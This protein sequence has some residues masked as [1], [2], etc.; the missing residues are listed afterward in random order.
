MFDLP[1]AFVARRRYLFLK[2]CKAVPCYKE[3]V[4][5]ITSKA[6]VTLQVFYRLQD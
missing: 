3:L 6:K 2:R 5:M 1:T 4:S